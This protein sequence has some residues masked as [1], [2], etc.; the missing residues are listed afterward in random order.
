LELT[1][2]KVLLKESCVGRNN[3]S[4]S[5]KVYVLVLLD[6]E[7]SVVWCLISEREIRNGVSSAV[8]H[9]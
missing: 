1:S 5:S 8:R 2:S 9:V 7:I 6:V 3:T 4:N